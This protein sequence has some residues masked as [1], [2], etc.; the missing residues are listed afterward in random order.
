[1]LRLGLTPESEVHHEPYGTVRI[2]LYVDNW[3]WLVPFVASF[4]ADVAATEPTE[5][6]QAL[7][8]H[9]QR[10]LAIYEREAS[11]DTDASCL[12]DDSRR[13]ATRDRNPRSSR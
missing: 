6:R 4:G 7:R 11:T 12:H 2:V 10:A 9:R 3:Q 1:M 5:L 13:R 8:H